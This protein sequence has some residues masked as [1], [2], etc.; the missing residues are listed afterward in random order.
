MKIANFCKIFIFSLLNLLCYLLSIIFLTSTYNIKDQIKYLKNLANYYSSTSSYCNYKAYNKH[1]SGIAALFTFITL[2]FITYT[3]I[4]LMF[5]KKYKIDKENNRNFLE[6]L[7]EA[8]NVD[9]RNNENNIYNENRVIPYDQTPNNNVR[10]NEIL[11]SYNSNREIVNNQPSNKPNF[12][13]DVLERDESA[14][15]LMNLLLGVFIFCQ[16]LYFVE[17]IVLSA[18]HRKSKSMEKSD[19][20]YDCGFSRFTRIYRDLIIVGYIIFIVFIIFYIILLIFYKKLGERSEI[21]LEKL[22]FCKICD[23]CI[24]E[25]CKKCTEIFKTKTDEEE[26][27]FSDNVPKEL[28]GTDEEKEIYIK[29]LKKYKDDLNKY[30]NNLLSET[31]TENNYENIMN[32]LH[33]FPIILKKT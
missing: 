23:D 8:N 25:L 17:L 2:G 13:D 7:G 12:D 19:D 27:Q 11:E 21:T 5:I 1:Y 31:G 32:E 16:V 33:L 24:I 20:L 15:F 26:K 4:L 14:K 28:E 22:R 9:I 30:N 18:F 29:N 3:I 6:N 10:P